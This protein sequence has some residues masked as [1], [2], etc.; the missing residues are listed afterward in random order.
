MAKR[1]KPV[2]KTGEK[3][4][5]FSEFSSDEE[6]E[7]LSVD[8]KEKSGLDEGGGGGQSLSLYINYTYKQIYKWILYV[9]HTIEK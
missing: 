4:R 1:G 2:E 3:R 7:S 6:N 5:N 9:H 8:L